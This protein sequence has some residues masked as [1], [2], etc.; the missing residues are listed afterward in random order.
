MTYI[1]FSVHCSAEELLVWFLSSRG[2][3]QALKAKQLLRS[4]APA[5]NKITVMDPLHCIDAS[6]LS[7][8]A[9]GCSAIFQRMIVAHALCHT[10][11]AAAS[12]LLS[13]SATAVP[14]KDAHCRP[15]TVG[16]GMRMRHAV[17]ACQN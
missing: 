10:A 7:S 13:L 3:S 11:V 5:F 17:Q 15:Y 16:P 9:L 6:C 4:A 14:G 12:H 2:L 1:L 8:V